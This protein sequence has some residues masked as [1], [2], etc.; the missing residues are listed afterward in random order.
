MGV[1]ADVD[2]RFRKI[3]CQAV[4]PEAHCVEVGES[5]ACVT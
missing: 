2:G 1:S 5:H 4:V 3:R